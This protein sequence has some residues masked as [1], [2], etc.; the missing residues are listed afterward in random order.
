M[1]EVSTHISSVFLLDLKYLQNC[2]YE[3]TEHMI[4]SVSRQSCMHSHTH[5]LL[6]KIVKQLVTIAL[7]NL[8]ARSV[9]FI[10]FVV[11]KNKYIMYSCLPAELNIHQMR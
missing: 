3:I 9:A 1:E 2:N 8:P 6:A 11:C 5:S 10:Q 4:H 7:S